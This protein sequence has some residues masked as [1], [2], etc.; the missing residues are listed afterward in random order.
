MIIDFDRSVDDD[1]D[2]DLLLCVM[3]CKWVV[4]IELDDEDDSEES[5]VSDVEEIEDD[6]FKVGIFVGFYNDG[7]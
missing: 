1:D 5:S 7:K 2:E 3:I 4:K 6:E